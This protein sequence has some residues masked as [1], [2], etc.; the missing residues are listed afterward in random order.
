M[1]VV[2]FSNSFLG[3]LTPQKLR[4]LVTQFRNW[5]SDL[6]KLA[7]TAY[8][9]LLLLFGSG[10]GVNHIVNQDTGVGS[11]NSTKDGRERV[12]TDTEGAAIG[13]YIR[14]AGLL[15]DPLWWKH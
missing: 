5:L 9:L 3:S 14:M 1:D 8:I 12:G 13:R 4:P 2:R 11:C 15:E 10:G 6:E 7:H